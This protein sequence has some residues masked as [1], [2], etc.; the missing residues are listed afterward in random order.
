MYS[1]TDRKMISGLVLKYLKEVDL[2]ISK[3]YVTTLP[4]SSNL[5]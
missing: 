4:S 5:L 1:F 2:V 3:R